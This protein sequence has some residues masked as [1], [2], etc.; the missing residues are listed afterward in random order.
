M[1]RLNSRLQ[2]LKSK[3]G[4]TLIEL[5]AVI[6]IIAILVLIA[7][8]SFLG[9]KE[10]ATLAAVKADIKT[11]ELAIG[12]HLLEHETLAKQTVNGKEVGFDKYNPESGKDYYSNKGKLDTPVGGELYD[13]SKI[14]DSKVLDKG[15]LVASDNGKV[16]FVTDEGKLKTP[17]KGNSSTGE[18]NSGNNSGG[19]TGN[20]SGTGSGNEAGNGSGTG[21]ENETGNGSGTVTGGDTG[22]GSDPGAGGGQTPEVKPEPNPETDFEWVSRPG[23]SG[24]TF[25][26]QSG[27]GYWKYVG[28]SPEVVIPEKLGGYTLTT[29]YKMFDESPVT[30]VTSTNKK[31]TDMKSMFSESR[32]TSLDLSNL[33]TSNVTDMSYMFH[34]SR[35]TSLDL[36]NFDTSS[37]TTM[38][39]MFHGS[40]VASL[41]LSNFDTREVT[42][43]YSMFK[44][45]QATPLDLSSFDTSIVTDMRFM[46]EKSQATSLDLRNF[47]ISNVTT[48]SHMFAS[49]NATSAIVRTQAE[50]DEFK[51]IMGTPSKLKFTV[52]Q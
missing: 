12:R 10:K 21:S 51:T 45:S 1:E 6:A 23:Y 20:G 46:F 26:G 40:K 34:F 48:K 3:K 32:G 38:R 18:N 31:V 14:I 25:P 47:D 16:Y 22:N 30:K 7:A 15:D 11:A 43:M 28:A 35:T 36:S 2:K 39:D 29:Y 52:K 4:F 5:L 42:N 24:Y 9:S 50:A 49:S 41:D 17:G 27:E 19:D 8:P 44:D 37:V 33:D 13:I